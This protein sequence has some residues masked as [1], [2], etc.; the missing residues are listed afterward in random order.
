MFL[1]HFESGLIKEIYNNDPS[2]KPHIRFKWLPEAP[3]SK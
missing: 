1:R 2:T 3:L